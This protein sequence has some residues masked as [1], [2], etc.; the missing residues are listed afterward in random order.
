MAEWKVERTGDM[1]LQLSG[2]LKFSDI[3]AI[4]EKVDQ[5][6]GEMSGE[7]S[8][9]F[10]GVSQVDSSALSLWLCSMRRAESLGLTLKPVNVPS[11]MQSI[12]GLVGLEQCFS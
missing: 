11:E 7:V 6:L 1:A 5:L 10:S 3:T 8:I 4:R 12:A 9:D 2:V